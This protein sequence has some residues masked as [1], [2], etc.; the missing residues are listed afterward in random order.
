[1][2]DLPYPPKNKLQENVYICIKDERF[3]TPKWQ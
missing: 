2:N 3:R 1:M